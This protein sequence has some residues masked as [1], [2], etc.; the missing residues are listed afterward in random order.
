MIGHLILSDIDDQPAPFS[1]KI[2][3]ELLRQDKFSVE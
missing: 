2:V 3:T 1:H